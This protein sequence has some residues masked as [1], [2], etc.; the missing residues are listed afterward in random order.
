MG[1]QHHILAAVPLGQAW[2][3]CNWRLGG[4]QGRCGWVWKISPPLGCTPQT[5]HPISNRY[6]IYVISRD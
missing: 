1:G 4:P 6:T 3:H 2:Y 5:V